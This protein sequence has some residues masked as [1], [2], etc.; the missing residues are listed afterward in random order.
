MYSIGGEI[1]EEGDVHVEL[2]EVGVVVGIEM[3]CGLG[4]QVV[5]IFYKCE[6]LRLLQ[7]LQTIARHGCKIPCAQC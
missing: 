7:S 2:S 3:T 4:G 6:G 5:C 1:Q